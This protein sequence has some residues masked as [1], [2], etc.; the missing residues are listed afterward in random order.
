MPGLN[1]NI[2]AEEG[3]QTV[4]VFLQQTSLTKWELPLSWHWPSASPSK[5]R[6]AFSDRLLRPLTAE[7]PHEPVVASIA[8]MAVPLEIPD[9]QLRTVRSLLMKEY[10]EQNAHFIA[11]RRIRLC[12]L[13]LKH[14]SNQGIG[15][16]LGF[17]RCRLLGLRGAGFPERRCKNSRAPC[18][19]RSRPEFLHCPAQNARAAG[20]M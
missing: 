13:V 7:R 20:E 10:E 1:Y 16:C 14:R 19:L 4:V 2:T 15:A 3:T 8:A 5:C 18:T 6:R 17:A 11:V 12:R 9:H